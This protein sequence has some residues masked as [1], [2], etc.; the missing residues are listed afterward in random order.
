MV[1][2]TR[3]VVQETLNLVL[4]YIRYELFPPGTRA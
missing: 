1:Q 3:I 2:V 4:C